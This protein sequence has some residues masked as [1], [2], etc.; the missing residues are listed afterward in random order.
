MSQAKR[1]L[2]FT[3]AALPEQHKAQFEKLGF[4]VIIERPNL[5]E[6]ELIEALKEIDA[7]ILCGA[8]KFTRKVLSS[9]KRLKVI[10][11]FGVGYETYIDATALPNMV[12]P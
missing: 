4:N 8:E 1:N 6:D 7:H 11:F 10:S 12:L 3:G 5:T 2:L 9:A